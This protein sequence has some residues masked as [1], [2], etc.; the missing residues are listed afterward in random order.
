MPGLYWTGGLW[1]WWILTHAWLCLKYVCRFHWIGLKGKMR[2]KPLMAVTYCFPRKT[3]I[4]NAKN[5]RIAEQKPTQTNKQTFTKIC[6][7]TFWSTNNE[8]LNC[9]K[10]CCSFREIAYKHIDYI[11]LARWN[12]HFASWNLK[13]PFWHGEI[14]LASSNMAMEHAHVSMITYYTRIIQTWFPS[15]WSCPGNSSFLSRFVT[16]NPKKI[17]WFCWFSFG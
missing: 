11:P 17:M 8:I 14:R 5:I 1:S 12:L 7:G 15:C 4:T 2:G 16:V 10:R 13:S 3:T 9:I 6:P